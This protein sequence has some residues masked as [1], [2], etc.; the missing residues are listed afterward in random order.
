MS[1]QEINPQIA[2]VPFSG[3]VNSRFKM[4]VMSV[5]A[6]L[7][8]QGITYFVIFIFVDKKIEEKYGQ[9]LT[10]YNREIQMNPRNDDEELAN[11][12]RD[13]EDA[14]GYWTMFGPITLIA[15]LA[16]LAC[17]C[18]IVGMFFNRF[19]KNIARYENS[20]SNP[21]QYDAAPA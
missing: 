15:S 20:P 13:L 6:Q 21:G 10:Q 19:A 7:V 3:E 5:F 18:S 16:C 2:V 9:D 4:F 1:T 17:Q 11:K 14:Q 8:I 12:M